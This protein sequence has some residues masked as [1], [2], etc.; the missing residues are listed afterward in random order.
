MKK[1]WRHLLP[2]TLSLPR[3]L[4]RHLIILKLT[5]EIKFHCPVPYEH[6]HPYHCNIVHCYHPY[7]T[8]TYPPFFSHVAT[9]VDSSTVTKVSLENALSWTVLL[10]DSFIISS[11]IFKYFYIEIWLNN[12]GHKQCLKFQVKILKN[13]ELEGNQEST[14]QERAF[15]CDIFVACTM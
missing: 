11:Y 3:H 13:V 15:S 10:K 1:K 14:G 6:S 9:T 8:W 5:F 7:S 2:D 4:P 12:Y